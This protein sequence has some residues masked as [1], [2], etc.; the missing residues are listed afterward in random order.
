MTWRTRLLTLAGAVGAL[1]FGIPAAAYAAG[2]VLETTFGIKGTRGESM[3]IYTLSLDRGG[4]TDPGKVI[5]AWIIDLCWALHQVIM[6]AAIWL[7]DWALGYSWVG[8][9]AA[10]LLDIGS[11]M[12]DV[13]NG[14]GLVPTMLTITALI[15]GITMARGRWAKGGW[16]IAL[17]LI[18]ACLASG[19]FAQP[20]R[21]IAGEDGALFA[22][23]DTGLEVASAVIAKSDSTRD[24]QPA[25]KTPGDAKNQLVGSM[26]DTFIRLPH[27][28]IN[29]GD[30]ID[31]KKCADAYQKGLTEANGDSAKSTL[32]D[33]VKACDKAL[34]KKA[35]NPDAYMWLTV[36][37]IGPA[38][39]IFT[40]LAIVLAGALI[41]SGIAAMF[42]GLKAVVTLITGLLPGGA[43]RS[44]L[45]TFAEAL[46]YLVVMIFTTVFL[47]LFLGI[48][49]TLFRKSTNPGLTFIIVD[50]LLVVAIQQF[51]MNKRRIQA[52]AA[53]IAN[54]LSGPLGGGSAPASIP[55]S[56]FSP[57]NA[58]NTVANLRSARQQPSMQQS[59]S[60][61]LFLGRPSDPDEAPTVTAGSG[62]GGRG[63]G[64]GGPLPPGKGAGG[65]RALPGGGAGGKGA[66]LKQVLG[67][68]TE[69][70]LHVAGAVASGGTSTVATIASVAA[71][72]NKA[73][74]IA[75]TANAGRKALTAPK[76][77]RRE[78][79]AGAISQ[80]LPPGSTGG[81]TAKALALP[82]PKSVAGTK[83]A[84]GPSAQ[85]A[86]TSAPSVV[87]GSP[88][89]GQLALTTGRPKPETTGT[90]PPDASGSTTTTSSSS[91]KPTGDTKPA[92]AAPSPGTSKPPT[93]RPAPQVLTPRPVAPQSVRRIIRDGAVILIPKE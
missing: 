41:S 79:I 76:G 83:A 84:P 67:T 35:D 43:K 69:V 6:A 5:W 88:K 93:G 75:A 13:V 71:K 1:L 81:K 77:Q 34:G 73:R 85:A 32:R 22:A 20:V 86:P 47:A 40:I 7:I 30:F 17:S 42:Q 89:R 70:G 78:A 37:F 56:G 36:L 80:A 45:M 55:S 54:A 27:Q 64:G 3:W 16:D 26:V 24:N 52:A 46:M 28:A 49:Q 58:L 12:Q 51:I 29:F 18:I 31:G 33:K 92:A 9:V 15:G 59:Q 8:V 82:S 68:A 60:M 50:V 2:G 14:L 62:G 11:A 21:Y 63:G 4:A 10:P 91:T 66:R 38:A 44:F 48:I 72:A 53:G 90:K 39:L 61:N 25:P 87:S 65:K 23:R 74:Q 19:V 57:L